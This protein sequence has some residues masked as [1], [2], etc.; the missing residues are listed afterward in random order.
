MI[1][2]EDGVDADFLSKGRFEVEIACERFPAE[3]RLGAWYDPKQ[4]RVRA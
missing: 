3:L 4:A 2:S 1:R